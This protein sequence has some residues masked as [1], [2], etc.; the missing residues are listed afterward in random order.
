MLD[1]VTPEKK[2]SPRIVGYTTGPDENVVEQAKETALKLFPNDSVAQRNYVL[3]EASKTMS[4]GIME[5]ND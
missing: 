2:Q 4:T 1:N 5:I 3:K